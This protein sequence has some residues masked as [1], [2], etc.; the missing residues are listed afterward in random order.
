MYVSMYVSV[1]VSVSVSVFVS[2]YVCIHACINQYVYQSIHVSCNICSNTSIF[3]ICIITPSC[4]SYTT[5]L[6]PVLCVAPGTAGRRCRWRLHA[7]QGY[8]EGAKRW[9]FLNICAVH[10]V[11]LWRLADWKNDGMAWIFWILSSWHIN[12]MTRISVFSSSKHRD[13]YSLAIYV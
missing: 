3:S 13:G 2:M 8:R 1:Y 9:P 6:K 5:Q 12:K 10:R 7:L 4:W 11:A